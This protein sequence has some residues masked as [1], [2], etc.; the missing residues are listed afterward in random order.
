MSVLAKIYDLEC[1]DPNR[2][3]VGSLKNEAGMS[4]GP[5]P[6]INSDTWYKHFQDLNSIKGKFSQRL[7]VLNKVLSDMERPKT[8]SFLDR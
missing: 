6:S 7:E 5:E 4:N 3:L 8:F 1:S 2:N